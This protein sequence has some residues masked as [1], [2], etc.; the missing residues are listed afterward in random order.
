MVMNLR[1]P[2][3]WAQTPGYKAG[4]CQSVTITRDYDPFWGIE[5]GEEIADLQPALDFCNGE[6]D[7][8]V[9]PIREQCLIFALVNNEK[10]GVWGGTT[11]QTRRAIRKQ[12]PLRR[13]KNP[14]PEWHWMTEEAAMALLSDEER[15][16]LGSG[17]DDE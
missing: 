17:E 13:G 15:A 2:A 10:T 1:Q 14:R 8:V 12:W 11:P 9:C 7:G 3:P 16:A 6:A 5:D 4:K